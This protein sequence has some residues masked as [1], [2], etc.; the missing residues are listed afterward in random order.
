MVR[1]MLE[2]PR[3]N[4]RRDDLPRLFLSCSLDLLGT[5]NW[6]LQFFKK[7]AGG[8]RNINS[9]GHAALAIFH[10]LD[11]AGIFAALGTCG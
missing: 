3:K 5:E 9:A 8:T 6:F 2:D 7:L 4:K 10:A 1:D 11:D